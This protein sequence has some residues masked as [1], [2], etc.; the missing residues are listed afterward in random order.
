MLRS[1]SAGADVAI[2]EGGMEWEVLEPHGTGK[3]QPGNPRTE[4]GPGTVRRRHSQE[5]I[6]AYRFTRVEKPY[7]SLSSGPKRMLIH[8]SEHLAV[9][10]EMCAIVL[11][12]RTREKQLAQKN[13]EMKVREI[14]LAIQR[15]QYSPA[16]SS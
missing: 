14:H 7:V 9:D 3:G 11:E 15:Y 5:D 4:V 6:M 12:L 13:R 2:D 8:F 10:V 16:G 1:S